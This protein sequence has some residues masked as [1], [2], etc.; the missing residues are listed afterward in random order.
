MLS[1]EEKREMKEMARSANVREE[2]QKLSEATRFPHGEPINLD[3]FIKFLTFMS[4][5]CPTPPPPR[6]PMCFT[7]ALL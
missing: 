5:L 7:R 4:R 3:D 1:E 2:F 6:H